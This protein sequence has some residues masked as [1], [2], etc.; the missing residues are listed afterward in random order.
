MN[1]YMIRFSDGTIKS[2]KADRC[3]FANAIGI[4]GLPMAN[5]YKGTQMIYSVNLEYVSAIKF[6][7][8]K[9]DEPDTSN[10]DT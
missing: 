1:E 7:E 10:G 4:G 9:D 5:F 3:I 6:P 2:I 8:V